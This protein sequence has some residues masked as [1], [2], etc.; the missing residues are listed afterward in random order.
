[1][2]HPTQLS[3]ALANEP[4]GP[5]RSP[6]STAGIENLRDGDFRKERGA[7]RIAIGN[8]G[9]SWPGLDP[10]GWA[11]Q[12]IQQ[13]IKGRALY[14][15]ISQLNVR[16]VRMAA[17]VEQL[18]LADSRVTLSDQMD[19]IGIPR[20]QVHYV[21]DDYTLKGLQEARDRFAAIFR[22]SAARN[23]RRSSNSRAPAT[24]WAPIAWE[25]TP[26]HRS[27]MPTAGAGI[28]RTCGSPDLASFQAS[29]RRI[30][31]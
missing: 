16:A 8:D 10:V 19:E 4:M 2:D 3:Y 7:F 26:G 29:A 28:I 18:P 1:M 25:P 12:L 24:S 13:G 11:Q 20:P 21:I 5:Y 15:Q 14:G 17:L 6:L 30:R 22:R 23:S 27:P 31:R 9:W